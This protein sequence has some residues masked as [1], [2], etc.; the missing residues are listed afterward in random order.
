MS[1]ETT[2]SYVAVGG[3]VSSSLLGQLIDEVLATG[4][5]LEL[6]HQPP[7]RAE[8]EK[9]VRSG[10]VLHVGLEETEVDHFS[11]FTAYLRSIGVHHDHFVGP[12]T[13]EMPSVTS[14]RGVTNRFSL[15]DL[16][17]NRL[18]E[19]GAVASVLLNTEVLPV[20]R[21]ASVLVLVDPVAEQPLSPLKVI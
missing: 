4:G 1:Q 16:D 20:D 12:V 6:D 15:A 10:T 11:G 14:F 17:G 18:I 21:V 9:A 3:N 13:G 7:S 19:K 2:L 8:V 5:C